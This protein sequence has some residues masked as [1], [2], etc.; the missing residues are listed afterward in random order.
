MLWNRPE[1]T[2][3]VTYHIILNNEKIDSCNVTDYTIKNLESDTE[4]KIQVNGVEA[5][6]SIVASNIITG[7]TKPVSEVFNIQTYG[8]VADGRTINTRA[9]QSAV[10]ACSE[11]GTVYV[12][13]GTFVT[14]AL[15]S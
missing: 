12:P 15:F 14:G 4:Y 9:I 13:K 2:V 8:A 6:G 7:K 5:D 11:G 10:N 3:T 1:K